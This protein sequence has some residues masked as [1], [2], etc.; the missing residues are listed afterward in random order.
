MYKR[1]S[2]G[3]QEVKSESFETAAIKARRKSLTSMIRTR[4]EEN[5]KLDCTGCGWA[6]LRG[7]KARN[8]IK[9]ACSELKTCHG[10]NEKC[11]NDM[12]GYVC[13]NR[14]AELSYT[15]IT[16]MLERTDVIG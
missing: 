4:G 1:I 9:A 14:N 12:A 7:C 16:Q 6:I 2:H 8:G 15:E 5:K 10:E 3:S 13:V 11:N